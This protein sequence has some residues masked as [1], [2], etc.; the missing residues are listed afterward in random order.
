MFNQ[1][2]QNKGTRNNFI[3]I[4]IVYNMRVA[5]VQISSVEQARIIQLSMDTGSNRSEHHTAR[6]VECLA[7]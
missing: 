7:R 3:S 4:V 6:L 2:Q 5:C 1:G